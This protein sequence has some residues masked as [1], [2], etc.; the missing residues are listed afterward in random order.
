MATSVLDATG[1]VVAAVKAALAV[2]SITGAS[3]PGSCTVWDDVP[4]GTPFP[5]IRITDV[6]ARGETLETMGKSADDVLIQVS[7]FSQYEG[8]LEARAIRKQVMALLHNA[9]LSVSGATFV[10]CR[11]EI[12]GDG[13]DEE[14]NGVVTRHRYVQFRVHVRE[15]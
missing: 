15:S 9:T 12:S 11:R 6:S 14:I 5:Y 2:A 8:G 7:V 4:Q 1:E 13:A 3:W 10:S